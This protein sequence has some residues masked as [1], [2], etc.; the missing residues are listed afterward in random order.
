MTGTTLDALDYVPRSVLGHVGE[1]LEM[2]APE[3]TTLRALYRRPMTLFLHSVG[4]VSTPA[5][6]GMMRAM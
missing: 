1:Q 4:L 2:S 3:L 6:T 5:F